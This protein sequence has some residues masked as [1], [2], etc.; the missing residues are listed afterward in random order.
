MKALQARTYGETA[1]LTLE[2]IARPQPGPGEVL[3]RVAWA[4]VNFI[5]IYM[6]RGVYR[7]SRTYPNQPPF[8]LGMEGSGTVVEAGP[9]TDAPSPGERVAWCLSLGSYAEYA[10]V[11]AWRLVQVPDN[12]DLRTAT[13]LMLQGS[14][15]HYLS[16]S[17]F[18]LESGHTCLIHAGAGGV[19]QLLT[20]L[21]KTRGARVISTVGSA[22]KARIA[23][24]LGADRVILY[25]DTDFEP[26]V[27]E[28]TDGAGVEVVYDSVGQDTF[29]RSLRCLHRRG[30]CVLFG[31]SS[32]AVRSVD[33]LE[34]AEAGSVFLTRPHLADYMA[35]AEEIGMRARDLFG[36]CADR[37]LIVRIDGEY[38]LAQ[39]AQAQRAL[40][41]R[42]SHGKLLLKVADET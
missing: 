10:V 35:D 37:R 12:V 17:A 40:A 29:A 11:P 24:E 32:G 36:A 4:G 19:G 26:A 21:A 9:D 18:A 33:P 3:V 23:S 27:R 6:R 39:G 16:H 31:G 1:V 20:Q 7:H 8:T 38:D 2:D 22:D 30:T 25:R 13:A 5:D 42:K 28:E 41:D 15:A 34:L 14:T